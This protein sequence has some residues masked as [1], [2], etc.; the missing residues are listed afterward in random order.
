MEDKPKVLVAAV[1]V[2]CQKFK[3]KFSTKYLLG[4]VQWLQQLTVQTVL[5]T[6][7][8]IKSDQ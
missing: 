6:I 2:T 3:L 7:P 1:V 4:I 5:G 8:K